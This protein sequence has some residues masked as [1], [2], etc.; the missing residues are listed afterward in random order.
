MEKMLIN[1]R[2]EENVQY[3]INKLPI[4]ESFDLIQ[5]NLLIGGKESCYYF[6]DGFTKDEVML[7]I[8]DSFFKVK[9]E[10]F[11]IDAEDFIKLNLPYV[12]VDI[13]DSF[14]VVIKN[15]LSGV[16]CL[17]IDGYDKCILID[18]RTYPARSVSEPVILKM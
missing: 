18:S 5:R 6:V 17:F 15:V 7:K 12:E 1:S 14:E 8:M 11:P 3:M 9:S 2:L 13:L 10:E 4:V 16:T